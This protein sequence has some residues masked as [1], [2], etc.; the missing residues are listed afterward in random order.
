[1]QRSVLAELQQLTI[2]LNTR[3]VLDHVSLT[4]HDHSIHA[5]MGPGAAGKSTLMRFLCGVQLGSIF[6][7]KGGEFNGVD[8]SEIAWVPQRIMMIDRTVYDYLAENLPERHT[9]TRSQQLVILSRYLTQHHIDTEHLFQASLLTLD[10]TLQR[11]L[12]ILRAMLPQPK[13][14]C[15][16]E[17]MAGL[18][19]EDAH[20]LLDLLVELKSECAIL[21]ISHHLSHVKTYA[22]DVT[23]IASGQMIESASCK[24]FFENPQ[25]EITRTYIRTGSCNVT[26]RDTP[27]EHLEPEEVPTE[28]IPPLDLENVIEDLDLTTLS[29]P[30]PTPSL[31]PDHLLPRLGAPSSHVGPNNFHWV[32]PGRLAGCGQP[33]L[34]EPL[35]RDLEALER[36]G[37]S[38]LITLTEE[39]LPAESKD[40][41]DFDIVFFPF[42]DMTAPDMD[43]TLEITKKLQ[44]QLTQNQTLVFHCKA[45]KGRTGTLLC[46]MLIWNGL[47]A[48]QALTVVRERYRFY[49]QSDEQEQ[50]IGHF[51][52]HVECQARYNPTV[53]QTLSN[54]VR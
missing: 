38:T 47:N 19:I 2:T 40:L 31:I 4:I 10:R 18:E 48:E 17:T 35:R 12:C 22:D 43:A 51:A 32:I 9:L 28:E 50:F 23:L 3:M 41:I 44:N 52:Q 46:A 24:E 54:S 37:C 14:L 36:T 34:L 13:L 6:E 26:P 45:G 39:P 1:M 29:D 11:K 8:P 49:V 25:S 30:E 21:W 33:G 16:D 27:L 53:Y 20:S 15:V 5:I 42:D 7:V